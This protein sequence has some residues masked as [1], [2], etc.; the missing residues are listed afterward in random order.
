M[1]SSLTL[2]HSV[3]LNPNASGVEGLTSRSVLYRNG[4]GSERRTGMSESRSGLTGWPVGRRQFVK[5]AAAAG[6]AAMLPGAFT[7]GS[8]LAA[9]A[10]KTLVIAAPSTPQGL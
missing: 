2:I 5:G 10:A 6:G 8:A 9:D 4:A 7:A 1:N 3:P